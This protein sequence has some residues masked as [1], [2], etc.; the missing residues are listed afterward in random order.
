MRAGTALPLTPLKQ[1]AQAAP[2]LPI[3]AEKKEAAMTIIRALLAAAIL[4]SAPSAFAQVA[5]YKIDFKRTGRG[6]NFDFY[7]GAYFITAAPQGAG[8][9]VFLISEGAQR[10]YTTSSNA[11]Q[12]FL[13]RDG[14]IL[15]ASIAGTSGP[16][17]AA[18]GAQSLLLLN[19]FDVRP[20]GIGGGLAAP[21]AD[22]LRGYFSAYKSTVSGNSTASGNGTISFIE[23]KFAGFAEAS[24]RLDLRLTREVNATLGT[25]AD[26]T[27]LVIE[28]VKRQGYKQE[29]LP[30][31][32][33]G[34]VTLTT[35]SFD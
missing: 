19:G 34:N 33:S 13:S 8:S 28:K 17:G 31:S 30:G 10:Y 6:L 3:C 21:L 11:G 29:P 23:D 2:A 12:L 9:F 22:D 5:V 15:M 32:G 26:G 4:A 1:P 18:G 24:G 7:D 27:N 25:V 16:A 35:S 20:R 14:S